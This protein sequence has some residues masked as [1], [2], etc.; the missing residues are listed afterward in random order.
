M[1]V[2]RINLW[3][4]ISVSFFAIQSGT[5]LFADCSDLFRQINMWIC[6]F[7]TNVGG[8]ELMESVACLLNVCSPLDYRETVR[9]WL[10]PVSRDRRLFM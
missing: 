9:E 8:E 6:Q 4:E 10:Q 2:Q 1:S 7:E 5:I 3:K